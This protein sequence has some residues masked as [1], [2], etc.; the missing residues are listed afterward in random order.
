MPG[1]LFGYCRCRVNRDIE[2]TTTA[3]GIRLAGQSFCVERDAMLIA[4]SEF[5]AGEHEFQLFQQQWKRLI[6]MAQI[7][8]AE[9]PGDTGAVGEIVQAIGLLDQT[10]TKARGDAA[11]EPPPWFADI[12]RC[13]RGFLRQNVALLNRELI[14]AYAA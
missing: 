11:S 1:G 14:L 5:T 10:G 2:I 8:V 9:L 6:E 7:S 4:G 13:Y 12:I 3:E